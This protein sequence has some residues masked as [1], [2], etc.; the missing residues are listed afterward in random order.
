MFETRNNTMADVAVRENGRSTALAVG[1]VAASRPFKMF[2]VFPK[3]NNSGNN[4]NLLKPKVPPLNFAPPKL[5]LFPKTPLLGGP[6][7]NLPA[8]A[9]GGLLSALFPL[10]ILAMLASALREMVGKIIKPNK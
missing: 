5:A 9:A 8:P 10:A 2:E 6:M 3:L 7:P 4:I 1:V